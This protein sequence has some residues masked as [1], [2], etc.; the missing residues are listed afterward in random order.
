MGGPGAGSKDANLAIFDFNLR[1]ALR[2]LC[3]N[4]AG[5]YN[6]WNLN[7]AGLHFGS[8]LPGEDVVTFVE[9]HDVDRISSSLSPRPRRCNGP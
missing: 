8:G 5:G 3:N 1:Y 9:N 7:G 2:D 6:M 4:G